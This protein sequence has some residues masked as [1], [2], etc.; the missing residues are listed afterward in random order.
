MNTAK[1]SIAAVLLTAVVLSPSALAG[2]DGRPCFWK[3][4]GH[5]ATRTVAET[6]VP[7]APAEEFP[8]PEAAVPPLPDENLTAR[9]DENGRPLAPETATDPEASGAPALAE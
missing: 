9:L 1:T 2:G 6:P 4:G 5:E 8:A 7:T 3:E